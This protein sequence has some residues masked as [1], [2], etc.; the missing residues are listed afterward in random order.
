MIK[1]ILAIIVFTLIFCD[2]KSQ[3]VIY[4]VKGTKINGK[5][6]EINPTSIKYKSPTNL[7][8]PNYVILR[9]EVVLIEYSNGTAQIINENPPP[10]SPQKPENSSTTSKKADQQPLNLYYLDKNLISINALSLANGDF[11]V[12]YDREFLNS[13]LSLSLLG[14]YNFNSRMG[15]LN[16]FII[17]ERENAK[18]NF[19]LGLAL[20]FMPKNTSRVQYFMGLM[21]KHMDYSFDKQ[22]SGPNS[23]YVYERTKGGQTAVMLTNGWLYRISSNFNFKLFGSI[24]PQFNSP[25]L[26]NSSFN[27]L[28]KLYFGY[29]FGYRFN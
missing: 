13:R 17:D 28:P 26:S 18:K 14:T 5:V 29:C 16:A 12:M 15:L 2:L 23:T 4:T 11:A 21:V 24:G 27:S 25:S 1:N 6:T 20:N 19:D 3:D 22:V 8:G 7:D 10:I 9:N